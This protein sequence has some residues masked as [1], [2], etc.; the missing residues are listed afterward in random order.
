[1]FNV[2]AIFTRRD[3]ERQLLRYAAATKR[4]MRE[5]LEDQARLF[6]TDVVNVTPPFSQGVNAT[7][8]RQR[9]EKSIKTNLNRLFIARPL[10]GTKKITHLFGRTDV[11][12][13]P[14]VVPTQERYPHVDQI[15]RDEK[16]RAKGFAVRGMRFRQEQLPV[17]LAKVR[18]IYAREKKNV[19]WLAGGWNRAAVTLGSKVP[20][21]VK[22]H[23]AAPGAISK[24]F[25]RSKL[26]IRIENRV[27]YAAGVGGMQKR[28]AFALRKRTD[29]MR[30]EAQRAIDGKGRYRQPRR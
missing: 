25:G 24:R 29:A 17:S 9:G 8:A 23:S 18:K 13:L 19:G 28:M 5:I 10:R 15:Y 26:S 21:W 4:D 14:Y 6:V 1:M 22:R 30:I 12:G 16:K 7:K 20:A 11:P 2:Q 3:F 27:D